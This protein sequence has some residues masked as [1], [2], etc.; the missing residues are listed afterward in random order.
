ME[1]IRYTVAAQMYDALFGTIVIV[2]NAI[3]SQGCSTGKSPKV[4][5][6]E[7]IK[8]LALII[9]ENLFVKLRL[10]F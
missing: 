8:R 1:A 7:L 10:Q 3:L 6:E 2:L 4:G 5:P 9:K